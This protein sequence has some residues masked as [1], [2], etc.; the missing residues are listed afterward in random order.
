MPG[1]LIGAIRAGLQGGWA[2]LVAYAAAKA[3]LQLPAEVPAW[4]DEVA[5]AAVLAAVVGLIQ[6]LERRDER[7]LLGRL[8]RRLA[9]ALMLWTRPAVYPHRTPEAVEYLRGRTT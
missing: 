2:W 8:G 6:W 4:L 5:F 3:G 9:G 1:W 7:T